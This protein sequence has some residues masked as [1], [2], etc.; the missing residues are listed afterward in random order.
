M[1]VVDMG[2]RGGLDV[3]S[4]GGVGGRGALLLLHEAGEQLGYVVHAGGVRRRGAV[5]TTVGG[6]RRAPGD[7]LG[8]LGWVAAAACSS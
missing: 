2:G 1:V 6:E 8:D 4:C 7:E 5:A 3:G